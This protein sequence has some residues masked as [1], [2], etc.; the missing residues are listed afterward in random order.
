M[1]KTLART[2]QQVYHLPD[3]RP[4]LPARWG[5]NLWRLS[6][7]PLL[8]FFLAPLTALLLRT[9]PALLLAS[10]ADA[11]VIQAVSISLKTTLISLGITLLLG[12]PLAYWMGRCQFAGKRLLDTLIDLPTVLPPSVAGVALLLTF[13]RRGLFGAVLTDWGIQIAFTQTAVIMAQVFIAASFYVRAASL[14]FAAVDTEIEQAAQL[15]GASRWQTFRYVILPLARNALISGG[16]MSWSRA[17][18]EFGATILF[19]G[20]LSGQTQTMPLAIYLGFEVNLD[21]ALTL[22]TLLVAVSGLSLLLVKNLL[23][24]QP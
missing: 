10:L 1:N 8:L 11:T 12:T 19:A 16:V 20:N 7:L 15:D 24:A 21:I 14:G 18:G 22:S 2:E 13:G 23:P 9:S 17:L 6:A 4:H 5:E 3:V